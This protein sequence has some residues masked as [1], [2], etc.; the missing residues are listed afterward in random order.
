M[1][2]DDITV[3]VGDHNRR[4]ADGE[5]QHRVCSITQDPEYS[6]EPHYSNDIAIL[7]LCQPLTFSNGK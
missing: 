1:D 7:H 5:S 2:T 3:W 4:V 6:G